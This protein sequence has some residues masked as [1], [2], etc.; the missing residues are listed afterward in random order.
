MTFT[1]IP[2]LQSLDD[3]GEDSAQLGGKAATLAELKRAGFPV[4]EGVVVTTEALAQV[5]ESADVGAN[6][7]SADVEAIPL[8][9]ELIAELSAAIERLGPVRRSV[10][11]I[12]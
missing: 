10:E 1:D 11:R 2:L 12:G 8:P 7:G 5:L 3:V 9:A 6:A 4:P